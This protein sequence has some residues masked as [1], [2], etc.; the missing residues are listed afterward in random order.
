MSGEGK[1]I[2]GLLAGLGLAYLLDPERGA[3]RRALVRDKA[4]HVGRKLADGVDATARDVRNRTGGV[5]A[6]LRSRIRREEVGDEILHERVR[7]AIGRSVLHPKAITVVV[8]QGRVTLQGQVLQNELDDLLRT[9]RQVRGVSEV[10]NELEVHPEPG[11]APALQ[12]EA[13]HQAGA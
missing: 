13:A 12:G 8:Y 4:T 6:E 11:N 1:F 3:R 7:S 2:G 10:V 9:A 5:A